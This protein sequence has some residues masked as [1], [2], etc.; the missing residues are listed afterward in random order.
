MLDRFKF[1]RVA[2]IIAVAFAALIVAAAIAGQDNL[3]RFFL[4]PRVPYQTYTPPTQPDYN[5]PA[6]WV[7]A[8]KTEIDQKD[9][10]IFVVTPTIYWGGEDWNTSLSDEDS[11]DR[12]LREAIPNW[13]GPFRGAGHV[14]VPKYRA[15]SLYSFLTARYDARAARALAYSDVLAAFDKFVA[16]ID[17]NGPIVLVGVEQGGLHV[18]GLLQDRF[19]DQHMRE[20]LAVAYVIDFAVPLD[21]FEAGLKGLLVCKTPQSTQC[22]VTYNAFAEE[23][24][25]EITRFRERSMVWD[26]NGRLQNTLGR[27]LA[28][29][30][31]VLGAAVHDF[32]PARLHLGGVAASGLDWAANPAPIPGQTSTQCEEGVLLIEAPRSKSLRKELSLGKRFKPDPFNLFY[33]DLSKDVENRIIALKMKFETEGRLAPPFG[34]M[35]ELR[36]SPINKTPDSAEDNE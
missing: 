32:A 27:A 16:D 29:V 10:H 26:Q 14:T 8:P 35:V 15:A 25:L 13:A 28:C 21:L 34:G 11:N 20:R 6:S 19:H 1:L 7:F 33:A 18:L 22:V 2:L 36:D 4:D 12:L 23:D 30:N 31:P 24:D 9:T 3:F 5:D 17:S